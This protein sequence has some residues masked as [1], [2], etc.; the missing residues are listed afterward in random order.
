MEIGIGKFIDLKWEII[1]VVAKE[2]ERKIID[3]ALQERFDEAHKCSESLNAIKDSI[4][5]IFDKI[6]ND[7]INKI[8]K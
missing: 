6:I 1:G 2:A 7:D 3:L 8:T 4:S 5:G